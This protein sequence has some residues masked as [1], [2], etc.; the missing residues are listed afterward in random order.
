MACKTWMKL[1]QDAK[2]Q[3]ERREIDLSG[4]AIKIVGYHF[5]NQ[6]QN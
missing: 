1:T 5:Q 3:G 4:I 2:H 6:L